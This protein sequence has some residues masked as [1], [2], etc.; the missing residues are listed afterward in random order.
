MSDAG[1]AKEDGLLS[2]SGAGGEDGEELVKEGPGG[3]SDGRRCSGQYEALQSERRHA[4]KKLFIRKHIL[5][6]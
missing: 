2:C 4:G 5:E 3:K 6:Y 1:I